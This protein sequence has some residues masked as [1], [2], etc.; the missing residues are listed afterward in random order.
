MKVAGVIDLALTVMPHKYEKDSVP[1]RSHTG[2]N[3]MVWLLI[4][5]MQ[6]PCQ[7]I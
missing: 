6:N 3:L 1:E 7:N 2:K 4:S 5:D